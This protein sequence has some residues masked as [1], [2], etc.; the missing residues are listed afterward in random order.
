LI[1]QKT[2]IKVG[3]SG[4]RRVRQFH[5]YTAMYKPQQISFSTL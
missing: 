5:K 4:V 2:A 3:Q 1:G